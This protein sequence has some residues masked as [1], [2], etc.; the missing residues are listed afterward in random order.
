[1]CFRSRWPAVCVA[2]GHQGTYGLTNGH[3]LTGMWNG[4]NWKLIPAL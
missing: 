4:T 2:A 1:M 3:G